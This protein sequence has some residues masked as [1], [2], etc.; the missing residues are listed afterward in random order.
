[1]KEY[2][3][4]KIPDGMSEGLIFSM[5]SSRQLDIFG[6]KLGLKRRRFFF[7]KEPDFLF[8]IRIRNRDIKLKTNDKGVS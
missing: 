3:P 1:M 4:L 5:A 7:V 8:K 2:K 6:E